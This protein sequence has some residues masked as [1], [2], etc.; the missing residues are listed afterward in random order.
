MEAPSLWEHRPRHE[1][2]RSCQSRPASHSQAEPDQPYYGQSGQSP[3]LSSGQVGVERPSCCGEDS[4]NTTRPPLLTR[5]PSP[6]LE[7]LPI[8][9]IAVA[10]AVAKPSSTR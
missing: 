5:P 2:T 3:Q 4:R 10:V 1:R 9:T 7:V 6:T 8:T